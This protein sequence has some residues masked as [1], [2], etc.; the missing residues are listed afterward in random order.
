MLTLQHWNAQ[1]IDDF[2]SLRLPEEETRHLLAQMTPEN[3]E[4]A[5]FIDLLEGMRTKALPLS[6]INSPVMDCCGTGGSNLA[7]FNASTT[8][9]FILA[10]GGVPVIKFGNRG[11]SSRS[12]SFDLLERIG[13]P[14]HCSLTSLPDILND[15]GL[16]FLYA[17]Q[18]YPSLAHFSELRR[19][20][21]GRTVFNYMGPLLNPLKPS[22]RLTGVS[23]A[24]MFPLVADILREDPKTIRAWVVRAYNGLDEIAHDGPTD[25]LDINRD[26]MICWQYQPEF[27]GLPFNPD[28]THT[29][30]ENHILFQAIITGEDGQTAY[31]RISCLNAGA[32]FYLAGKVTSFE[33][34][35][36]MA[37][38]LLFNRK[39]AALVEKVRRIYA[40]LR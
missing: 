33:E 8:A 5:L 3:I 32:G 22:Y 18:V 14:S 34:G 20:V 27:A 9:A 29:P 21:G 24:K 16:V 7:R 28:L 11:I 38:D 13:I 12:G 40:R 31:H 1:D 19:A 25:I 39:V 30:E 6:P 36:L 26:A 10:A 17:P 4:P 2:L 15:C 37:E 23:D 35:V